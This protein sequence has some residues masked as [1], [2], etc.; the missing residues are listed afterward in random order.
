MSPQA[1]PDDLRRA[2]ADRY[3]LDREIGR[4]A[5]ATVYLAEDV[6]HQR[7]VAVKVLRPELAASLAGERFL[8]EISIAAQLQHPHILPLLDSGTAAGSLYFVMPFIEGE[9]LRERLRRENRLSISE[10][11]R[12]VTDVADALS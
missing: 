12:L 8:R 3:A 9:T 2:L 1:P 4:G 7:K 10:T 5:T 11:V 6:K